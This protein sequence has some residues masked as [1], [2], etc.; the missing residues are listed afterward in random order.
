MRAK[1]FAAG[2]LKHVSDLTHTERTAVATAGGIP[3]LAK[4]LAPTSNASAKLRLD[5]A[6]ALSC[7]A[8]A[9]TPNQIAIAKYTTTRGADLAHALRNYVL[10]AC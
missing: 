5:A 4:H 2:L 9:H 7:L 10:L 3:P 1:E 6:T 8:R